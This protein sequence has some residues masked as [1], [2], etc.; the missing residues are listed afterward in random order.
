M[1]LGVS[2][3]AMSIRK[4][5][6]TTLIEIV[7]VTAIMISLAAILLP[8]MARLVGDMRLRSA[9]DSVGS[10]LQQA[11]MRSVRDNRYY[12]VIPGAALQGP[13]QQ[14]CID[15]NWSGGCDV[16][17]P[18]IQLPLTVTLANGGGA[19]GT[20]QITCGPNAAAG[21]CPAGVTGLNFTPEPAA[22]LPVF[23][24]RGLPCVN[25]AG[26]A[27]EPVWPNNVCTSTDPGGG[28]PNGGLPVGFLYLFQYTGM[29]GAN[30]AA[31]VVT[32]AGRV[33]TW[34]YRGKD[35]GGNDVWSR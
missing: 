14:A 32:P 5:R 31:V 24:A 8:N 13:F 26:A 6:G 22:I 17:E 10:L 21:V 3:T 19:P 27:N 16:G 25:Q 2:G 18:L 29:L 1:V 4:Q 34:M 9:A 11:R 12:P 28:P 35:A 7:A 20:L 23:N 33:T 15:M 30:Y